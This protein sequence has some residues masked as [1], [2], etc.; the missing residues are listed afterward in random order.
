[1][2]KEVAALVR[3]KKNSCTKFKTVFSEL[4][5]KMLFYLSVIIGPLDFLNTNLLFLKNGLPSLQ[6]KR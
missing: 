5:K 3:N 4:G 1:M 2:I 6:I